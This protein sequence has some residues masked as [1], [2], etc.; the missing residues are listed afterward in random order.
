[1]AYSPFA[2]GQ[3]TAGTGPADR[4]PPPP[5]SNTRA[6]IQL[7][8]PRRAIEDG[9]RRAIAGGELRRIAGSGGLAPLQFVPGF[10]TED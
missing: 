8:D 1:M 10:V 3:P 7:P 6:R 9:D 2:T 4:M 5:Y